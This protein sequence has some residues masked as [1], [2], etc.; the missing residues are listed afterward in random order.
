[1]PSTI[2]PET[3]AL[4]VVTV[5]GKPSVPFSLNLVANAPGIFT[6]GIV[7]PDGSTNSTGTPVARGTYVAIYLT[8]LAVP[9]TGS[10]TVNIG[11]QVLIPLYAGAQG[12]PALDQ[13]NVTIPASLGTGSL[14][15]SVCVAG[16]GGQ[17][18]CSNV[19]SVY[20]Q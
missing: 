17:S 18:V 7:N 6:P 5:D 14:P 1:M 10:V 15:L 2:A 4:V 3:G 19:V 13:V 9:L 20:V 16:T 12:L 11:N 8:G